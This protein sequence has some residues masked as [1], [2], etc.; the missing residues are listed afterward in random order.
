MDVRVGVPSVLWE[1]SQVP[2]EYLIGRTD[3]GTVHLC[4]YADPLDHIIAE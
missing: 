3:V 4:N 2:S 1:G